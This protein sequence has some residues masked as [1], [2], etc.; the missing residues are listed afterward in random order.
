MKFPLRTNRIKRKDK[1]EENNVKLNIELDKYGVKLI[2]V[3]GIVGL[4]IGFI[5]LILFYFLVFTKLF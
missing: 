3:I 5:V 2:K 4:V 1:I